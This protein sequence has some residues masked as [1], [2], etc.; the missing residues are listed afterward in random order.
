MTF[1]IVTFVFFTA[2][3][4]VVTWWLTRNADL[5]TADLGVAEQPV[6]PVAEHQHVDAARLEVLLVVELQLGRK[7]SRT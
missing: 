7:R 4:A 2:L 1:T 5:D 3:V 6:V